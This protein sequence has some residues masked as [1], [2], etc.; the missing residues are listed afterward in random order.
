MGVGWKRQELGKAVHVRILTFDKNRRKT[1][2]AKRHE[3]KKQPLRKGNLCV[4]SYPTC[5]SPPWTASIISVLLTMMSL[6]ACGSIGSGTVVHLERILQ[7]LRRS[8]RFESF[9]VNHFQV[10][11]AAL[12]LWRTVGRSWPEGVLGPKK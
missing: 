9:K 2:T 1:C 5:S 6:S 12:N 4:D 10:N 3:L 11:E 7:K 8:C